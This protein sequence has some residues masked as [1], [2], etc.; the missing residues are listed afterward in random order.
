MFGSQLLVIP[1]VSPTSPVTRLGKSKGWLPPGRWV[2]IF[3]GLIYEG[4]RVLTFY[5]SLDKYPVFAKEGA[6]IPLDGKTGGELANGCPLP[7]SIEILLF[8]GKDGQFDL[9]EDDGSGA[10][11][12]DVKLSKTPIRYSQS[13]GTLTIGPSTNALLKKRSYSIRILAGSASDCTIK[14]DGSS[15]TPSESASDVIDIG[16]QSTGATITVTLSKIE[17]K[18][19]FSA[20][21]KHQIF[22]RL[23]IAQMEIDVKGKLWDAVKNADKDGMLK[24]IS[25]LDNIKAPEEIKS[26][27]MELLQAE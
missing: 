18:E 25:R 9:V 2:D 3:D 27:M 17:S 1:V 21:R 7:E 22:E 20:E 8:P 12:S 14:V 10:E 5:R 19:G 13:E 24:V 26:A 6:I 23:R 15:V 16:T 4:D 11:V